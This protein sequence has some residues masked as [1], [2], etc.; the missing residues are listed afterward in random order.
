MKKSELENMIREVVRKECKLALYEA[1]SE[2]FPPT[3]NKNVVVE[4]KRKTPHYIQ[5]QIKPTVDIKKE[6]TKDPILNAILNETAQSPATMERMKTMD[7]GQSIV[8]GG[9]ISTQMLAESF[10][11]TIEEFT[12]SYSAAPSIDQAFS[13]NPAMAELMAK[14]GGDKR[15]KQIA[16]ASREK[17]NGLR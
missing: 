1:L 9:G 3:S 4:N 6:Y 8:D 14:I 10:S 13:D 5:K 11:S 12:P 17:S 16:D 7:S 15:L 2:L